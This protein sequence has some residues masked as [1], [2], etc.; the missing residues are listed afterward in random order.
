MLGS[1]AQA[2]A[3]TAYG[4][5]VLQGAHAADGAHF[6]PSNS[7]FQFCECVS[8]VDTAGTLGTTSSTEWAKDP[9]RWFERLKQKEVHALRLH[10]GSQGGRTVGS[11]QVPERM[12]AGF[13]GGG[14]RWLI[15]AIDRSGSDYWEARWELGDRSRSD[16]RIWRVTY[17]RIAADQPTNAHLSQDLGALKRALETALREIGSYARAHQLV[18]FATLFECSR[19]Q[20]SADA[21]GDGADYPDLAPP[22]QLA[23]TAQQLLA[24]SQVAWVFGGMGSWN[25]YSPPQADAQEYKRVSEQLFA[26]LNQSYAAAANAAVAH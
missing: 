24:A 21:P 13:V 16:R 14:G 6:Y 19:A 22:G 12:L 18:N 15:E 5:A 10:Y 17:G 1:V 8:F 7:V 2:I 26:L 11:D 20:L 23:L 9:I 25:D 3:L 4:N